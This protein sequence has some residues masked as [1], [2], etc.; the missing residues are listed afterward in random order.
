[1]NPYPPTN[2]PAGDVLVPEAHR[3]GSDPALHRYMEP[4]VR[5]MTP[6][7]TEAQRGLVRASV[8]AKP[9]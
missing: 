1:M 7:E 9:V 6:A 5:E 3:M 2:W 4:S 8:L